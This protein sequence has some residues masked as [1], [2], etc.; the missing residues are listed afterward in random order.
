M[1]PPESTA[2]PVRVTIRLPDPPQLAFA[3]MVRNL[4]T[5]FGR[6][7]WVWNPGPGAHLESLREPPDPSAHA[8]TTE[9]V[10]GERFRIEW[11]PLPW[12]GG[13][14]SALTFAFRPV[15]DGTEVEVQW[16]GW[17]RFL[18]ARGAG[19]LA[20]WT[21]GELLAPLVLAGSTERFA[22]WL[23]DRAAR[24]PAGPT[25]VATYRDPLYH[26]PN[27]RAILAELALSPSDRLFEVG[28]GGGAFLRAAL[29]SGCTAAAIDHSEEM[30]R[31]ASEQNREAI[32]AGR[33]RIVHG[34]A[35]RLPFPD[36][37]FTCAVMTGVVSF[38]PDPLHA[39]IEVHRLLRPGGRFLVFAGTA[40]LRGTPAAPEPMA[41]RLTFY[42]DL[43]LADLARRAGFAEARVTTP[44]LST[45][46]REEGVPAE[47]WPLFDPNSGASQLLVATR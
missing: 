19:E 45:Y 24:R 1:S 23:T 40:A 25:S 34:D 47:A 29:A 7:R 39:F 20:G 28:C 13:E 4:A 8:V 22:D 27:F 26:R 31:T 37:E 36:G 16:T 38:L 6:A 10:P 35:T 41:S 12:A 3:E 33:L 15:E 46:A 43:E 5:A 21:A 30:V 17:S 44:D 42:K 32:E 18:V 9:W 11:P 14:P 2:A